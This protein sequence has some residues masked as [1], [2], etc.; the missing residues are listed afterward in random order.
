MNS[1]PTRQ[2][3]NQNPT[4][5]IDFLLFL[6][7]LGELGGKSSI[8]LEFIRNIRSQTNP[9]PKIHST[10]YPRPRNSP[11]IP[12]PTAPGLSNPTFTTTNS[13]ASTP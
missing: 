12:A 7:A 11:A 2:P 10:S 13:S 9:P 6:G 5:S 3:T 8:P 4:T 1:N